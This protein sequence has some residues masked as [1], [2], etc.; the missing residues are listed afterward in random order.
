MFIV[1]RIIVYTSVG[2]VEVCV[3]TYQSEI[4]PGPLRGFVVLSLQ[5]FLAAGGLLATGLNKAFSTRTDSSG[6]RIVVGLQF[7]FPIGTCH[8]HHQF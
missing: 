8:T 1:G 2:L 3:T 7:V 6:W 4:V 5:L